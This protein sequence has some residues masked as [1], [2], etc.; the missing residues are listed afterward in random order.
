MAC[1]PFPLKIEGESSRLVDLGK[2]GTGP[3]SS[4]NQVVVRTRAFGLLESTMLL[5]AALAWVPSSLS[6]C[7]W[8]LLLLIKTRLEHLR[9]FETCPDLSLRSYS[10]GCA[11]CPWRPQCSWWHLAFI[12]FLSPRLGHAVPCV[13]MSDSL[14]PH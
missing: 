3:G 10:S 14:Q 2:R 9:L 12:P 13:N 8:F 7:G 1:S 5:P 4:V 6:L 11:F